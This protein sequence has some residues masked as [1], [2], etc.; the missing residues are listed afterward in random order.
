MTKKSKPMTKKDLRK[1][2]N[3][4]L[5]EAFDALDKQRKLFRHIKYLALEM[6]KAAK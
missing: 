4:Y 6:E 3:L 5:D 1:V 2:M